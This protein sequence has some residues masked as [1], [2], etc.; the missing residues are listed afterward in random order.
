LHPAAQ[1]GHAKAAKARI[2]SGETSFDA[3][4]KDRGLE[5][6]DVDMGIVEKSDLGDAGAAVFSVDAGEVVGPFDSSIGPALFRVNAVLAAQI[7]P[8]EEAL[9]E[10]RSILAA[11]RAQRVIDSQIEH[12]D[13][14]LAGGATIEDL[15]AETDMKLG[16]IDWHPGLSDQIASYTAFRQAAAEVTKE[17][18]PKVLQLEDGG[19]FALRLDEVIE[20]AIRPF[21][22]VRDQVVQ[23]WRAEA[24]AKALKAQIT[25]KLPE[26][27]AGKSFEDLGMKPQ[28]ALGLTR[29]DT[30]ADAP[31]KFTETVFSMAQGE[32]RVVEGKGRIFVIRLDDIIKPDPAN[33]D[34][35]QLRS[36]VQDQMSASLQQDLFQL[37][38]DDIRARVGFTLN[39]QAL[40]AVHAN[41]Q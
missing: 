10:L 32:A 35:A 26:L 34:V 2:E 18:F 29:T 16:Q 28:S 5:L 1:I 12:I 27:Q 25:P 40:G 15:A 19:I 3:L 4:V 7:T 20:P 13:D 36:T 11:D 41:F 23:G 6:A 8:F 39:Q 22:A 38:A 24:V 30:Q 31:P 9:P 14:L 21:E 37:L 33:E 17:D